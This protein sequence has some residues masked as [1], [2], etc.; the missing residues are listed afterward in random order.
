MA[1]CNDKGIPHSEFLEWPEND[2]DKALAFRRFES[3]R[4]G[5][6]GTREEDWEEH[7]HAF[8]GDLYRCP[9]CEILEQEKSNVPDGE[10]GIHVR[11]RRNP[12]LIG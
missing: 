4:C 2:Q 5:T 3:T 9:G 10:K 6:C 1:F 12:K 11:L 7:R 8:I